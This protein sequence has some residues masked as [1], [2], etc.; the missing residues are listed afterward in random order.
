MQVVLRLY[1]RTFRD[2]VAAGA[3]RERFFSPDCDIC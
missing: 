2:N 3:V 1:S